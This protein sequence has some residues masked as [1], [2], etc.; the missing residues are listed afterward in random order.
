MN[1]VMLATLLLSQPAAGAAPSPS[2]VDNGNF[3]KWTDGKPDGWEVKIGARNGGDAPQS[4]LKKV[5]GPAIM[6][7]GTAKTVA[8]KSLSQA[9]DLKAGESYQL[10]FQSR[11]K[12]IRREGTQ[13]NN[14]Y[15]GLLAFDDQG[16]IVA[17]STAD[18]SLDNGDWKQHQLEFTVPAKSRRN[19]LVIFLS[20]SGVMGV[21][22]IQLSLLSDAAKPLPAGEPLVK[23]GGFRKWEDGKP[24]AWKKEIGAQNGAARPTSDVRSAGDS[25]VTFQGSR[26]TRA[27][28]SLSQSVPAKRR[29]TYTLQFRAKAEGVRR[30]GNQYNN[31]YVGVVSFDAA[32]NR[33]EM[34]LKDLS[35]TKKW[36]R[37]RVN[38]RVPANAT[39]SDL[40]V[41]LSKTGS[42]TI[43]DIQIEEATPQR[44]FR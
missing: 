12:D 18:V 7:R 32:G 20:K 37:H 26:D 14:C 31:C 38:F 44:P 41:F 43:D 42:L 6:L 10:R 36:E 34:A 25:G 30:E 40:T 5:K 15:V 17:R 27:W 2:I 29:K 24:A 33:L 8:W 28:Y 1:V 39:R 19:E 13:F 21:R 23:N 16:Q 4:E 35:A 3:E 9:V 11:T 22:N